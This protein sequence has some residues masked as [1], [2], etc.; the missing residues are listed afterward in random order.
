MITVDVASTLTYR[1]H[2]S[3]SML[4]KIAVMDTPNQS[5][6]A[7]KIQLTSG[8]HYQELKRDPGENRLLRIFVETASEFTVSYTASVS[9]T[10]KT[11][12]PN[13]VGETDIA[14]LP[15]SVYRFL[16]PSRYCESGLL[17]QTAINEFGASAKGYVRVKQISDWVASHMTYTPGSSDATTTAQQVL[18][19]GQGVCRDYA[20][21]AIA[22]C[23]GL[24]IPA[25][26][27][28]GYA[29]NLEPPDFH[30]F[31]EAY[32]DGDWYLFDPTKLAS[33]RGLVRIAEGLDAAETAFTTIFGSAEVLSMNVSAAE[34]SASAMASPRVENSSSLAVSTR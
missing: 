4:F 28:S 31:F 26:Y 22:F 11:Q 5:V 27:L 18:A 16:N 33:T 9:L 12:Q 10:P 25:R 15:E 8:V 29:V 34:T 30:G 6:L 23:R 13:E 21:L 2:S 24:G 7:E 32:L 3:A 1:T 17:G 14:E 20:H 19:S